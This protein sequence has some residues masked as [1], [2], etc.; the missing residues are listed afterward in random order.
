VPLAIVL[1]LVLAVGISLQPLARAQTNKLLEGLDGAT[2]QFSDAH[3]TLFPLRYQI[4]HLKIRERHPKTQEPVFYADEL[5]VSL[6]WSRLLRG[7]IAATVAARAV[8]VV[9]HQP[10]EGSKN[11][12]P[13]IEKLI[14]FRAAL[15]RAEVKAGEVLYVWV[16][17]KN[18][19]S[20]WFHSIEA[21]LENVGSRPGLVKGPMVLAGRGKVQRSGTMTV[22]ITADPY[23]TPLTFAGTV[24]ISDFNLSEMNALL[25]S[26]KDV[27]LT[28]GRFDMEMSFECERG[29]LRG[30]IDP[31]V[32][33]TEITSADDDLGS[34]LKAL[35]A[36]ISM[37][38]AT[39]AEGTKP[40]GR[41]N[42]SDD[43]TD[44]ELQLWPSMEKVV[45]NAF[46]LGVQEALKR[47]VGGSE[48]KH[49]DAQSNKASEL[50][51][52]P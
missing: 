1:L 32:R 40:S 24:T 5:A 16:R 35:L 11:R 9:L 23:A 52:R 36:K 43:L 28:S 29:R 4:T 22:F 15:E 42:V 8:K 39:P 6:R 41:I 3:V 34:R 38:V 21:T 19:P 44:P 47:Q 13:P 51:A 30:W 50:K 17:E 10:A 49:V 26:T 45:E 27:K 37:T 2:G 18:Q 46:L 25:A 12:L 14:P 33:G 31:R 20:V 48:K 7:Q